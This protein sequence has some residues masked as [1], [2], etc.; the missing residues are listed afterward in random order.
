MMLKLL[1]S[2]SNPCMNYT[3]LSSLCIAFRD[4]RLQINYMSVT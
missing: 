4:C 1:N 2:E 3:F